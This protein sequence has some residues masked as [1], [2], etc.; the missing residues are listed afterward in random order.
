MNRSD[1]QKGYQSCMNGWRQG[2]SISDLIDYLEGI[3]EAPAYSDDYLDG[4]QEAI[5]RCSALQK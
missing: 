1:Y 3:K 5:N 2:Y 4:Y